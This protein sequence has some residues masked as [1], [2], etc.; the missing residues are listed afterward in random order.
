MDQERIV[1][2]HLRAAPRAGFGELRRGL[3]GVEA[4]SAS[5]QAAS[6]SAWAERCLHQVREHRAFARGG[7]FAGLG[8]AAI[9]VGQFGRGEAGAVGHALAEREFREVAQ[10]LHR[11]GGR[12]DDVAEL[13]VVADLQAGDAVALRVVEL[14]GGEHPAAVVAQ[15]ALGV[16]FGVEAGDDGVA[17][18][19]AVRRGVGEG[20]GQRCSSEGS[21]VQ[22]GAGGAE[23][24]RGAQSRRTRRRRVARGGERACAPP[25][26]LPLRASASPAPAP[27]PLPRAARRAAPPGRAARRGPP[28]AAPSARAISGAARNAA[29]SRPA[30]SRSASSHAQRIL[31][32][33]DRRRIG[34][35]RGQPARQQPRARR[36]QRPLHRAEQ[37]VQRAA[38]ARPM[39]LQAGARRRIHRQQPGAALRR[40]AGQA[41]QRAGLGGAHIVHRH[42]RRD[43]LGVGEAAERVQAGDAERLGQPPPRH[44]RRRRRDIGRA[45]AVPVAERQARRRQDLR[46]LQPAE[47]RRAGPPA[48]ARRSRTGRWTRRARPRRRRRGPAPVPSSRLARPASSSASSVIVPGVTR[49]TTSRR[50]GALALRPCGR[51]WGPPSARPPR[52]GSRGGSAARDRPRR[53]AAARRTSGSACRRARRAG[54]ARC[55]ARRPRLPRR[56]RTARRSRP[57][58]RTPARPDAPPWRRTIAPWRVWRRRHSACGRMRPS[59][60]FT[61]H[62][63]WSESYCWPWPARRPK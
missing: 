7:A 57:C 12:L 32:R 63:R 2:G 52:R 48:P 15:R 27:Q 58:G 21:T 23:S 19:Q 24:E 29:R 41:R 53:H 11:G 16:E 31:P 55:R 35:R 1:V 39:D 49:R 47:Q 54:S 6:A 18:V 60:W 17:V 5:A 56:R 50:S 10:L 8:D 26:R 14:Q 43:R 37:R 62:P 34:E 40:R 44:Q 38:V 51:T 59:A 36:R 25:L 46:R 22:G 3:D 30:A 13:G 28:T 9:E 42:Q 33:R 61:P 45:L 4:A 20:G